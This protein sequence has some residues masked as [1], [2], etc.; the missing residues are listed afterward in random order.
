MVKLLV[1]RKG[2]GKT[3]QMVDLANEKVDK[4]KGDVVFI[5]KNHIVIAILGQIMSIAVVWL[6]VAI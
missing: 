2:S 6:D 1:G 3:K 5:N 4:L